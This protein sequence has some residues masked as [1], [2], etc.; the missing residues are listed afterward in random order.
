MSANLITSDWF[1]LS[2]EIRD[3]IY[4]HLL[5][6]KY[7]LVW[8]TLWDKND[9]RSYHPPFADIALPLA[10][11][12]VCQE[13][14][15]TMYKNSIFVVDMDY[16][17][18]Q[19]TP[20][21]SQNLTDRIQNI[22]IRLDLQV[23]R[24]LE[25]SSRTKA[26][27]LQKWEQYISAFSDSSIK[28]NS[29]EIILMCSVPVPP[30]FMQERFFRAIKSLTSYKRLMFQLVCPPKAFNLTRE[31][32]IGGYSPRTPHTGTR[33]DYSEMSQAIKTAFEPHLGA[34]RC[35]RTCNVLYLEFLPRKT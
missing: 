14:T 7:L 3:M 5:C 26:A 25:R 19:V 18:F 2:R 30:A 4:Y 33:K 21:P 28:R 31:D 27:L 15:E 35:Y 24:N 1:S 22:D 20:Q 11:N 13:A 10:S 34:A 9:P 6:K 12:I 17:L 16:S 23:Y 8:P 29:C 32:A